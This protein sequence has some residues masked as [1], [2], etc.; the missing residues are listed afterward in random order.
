MT[1]LLGRLPTAQLD[2][3]QL[4]KEIKTHLGGLSFDVD[5]YAKQG[6]QALCTPWLVARCSVLKENLDKAWELIPQILTSTDFD[7]PQ[8]I[9]EML[10]QTEMDMQQMAMGSGHRFATTCALAHF[11]AAGAVSEALG[12]YSPIQ[13]VHDF[14]KNFDER[15]PAFLALCRKVM[16]KAVATSRLVLGVTEDAPTDVTGLLA[17]L[18][19]GTPCAE[20]A[21]YETKLPRKLGVRI[22]AQVS[23]AGLGCSLAACGESYRGTAQLLSTVLS[24]SYLWNVVRVQGGAYGAGMGIRRSGSLTCHSYRDPSPAKTLETCRS[25]AD[26]LKEFRDSGESLDKF[27]ISTIAGMEPLVAPRQMGHI[28]DS[29]W[30]VG[31]TYEDALR[32]RKELLEASWDDLLAWCGVLEQLREKGAVCVVGHGEALKTCEAEGL[33]LVDL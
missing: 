28:A 32:E 4:Q 33:T 3:A 1:G 5:V 10:L 29:Q 23:Y 16:E 25:M 8:R 15:F 19:E 24:L 9:R 17:G 26:F 2:A 31:L 22:P 7:Q 11:S 20:A 27:I 14:V 13:W 12:A 30:F 6:Q 18:P 21:A